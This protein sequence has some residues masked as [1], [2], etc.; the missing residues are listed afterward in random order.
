MTNREKEPRDI[1]ERTFAFAL[2]IVRLSQQLD[3][4]SGV[5]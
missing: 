2:G 3:T 4:Q 5:S 1:K